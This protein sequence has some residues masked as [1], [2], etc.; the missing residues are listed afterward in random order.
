MGP[1]YFFFTKWSRVN[2]IYVG[3]SE[4]FDRTIAIN[5]RGAMLCYKYAAQQMVKQGRGGRIIGASSVA[6]REGERFL[7]VEVVPAGSGRVEH[8][9][10]RSPNVN[11]LFRV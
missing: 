2:F 11:G 8:E 5:L 7:K 1:H 4:L 10:D 9:Y 3:D 6:G